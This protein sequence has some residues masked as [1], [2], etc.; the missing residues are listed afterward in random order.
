MNTRM[1]C[2]FVDWRRFSLRKLDF[3]SNL[4]LPN[5]V[6]QNTL[7]IQ[8]CCYFKDV[9]Y[10]KTGKLEGRLNL[11]GSRYSKIVVSSVE[12]LPDTT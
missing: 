10:K 6:S 2:V 5:H 9:R 12:F 7:E 8:Y 1:P 3:Q 4:Q 11:W